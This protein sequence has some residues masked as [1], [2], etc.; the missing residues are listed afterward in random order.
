M[1]PL[2]TLTIQIFAKD[3]LKKM[4]KPGGRRHDRDDI[5]GDAYV[6]ATELLGKDDAS[7]TTEESCDTEFG[8]ALF[9]ALLAELV[10]EEKPVAKALEA[11]RDY[12]NPEKA[13]DS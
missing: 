13:P 1:S 4:R 6:R 5:F 10:D 2:E 8:A 12:F 11:I 3:G 9:F 7:F